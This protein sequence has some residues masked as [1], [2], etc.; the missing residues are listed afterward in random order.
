MRLQGSRYCA[1]E[2]GPGVPICMQKDWVSGQAALGGG[3]N[4]GSTASRSV[5]RGGLNERRDSS[6]RTSKSA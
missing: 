5:H 6:K 1:D 4:H 3:D 2:R